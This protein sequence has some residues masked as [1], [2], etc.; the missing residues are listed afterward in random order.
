MDDP[1]WKC[2]HHSI[3]L[4]NCVEELWEEITA[5]QASLHIDLDVVKNSSRIIYEA[6]PNAISRT[7]DINEDEKDEFIDPCLLR[8]T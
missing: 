8:A 4:S 5:L 7:A 1:N 6:N 2:S 3:A